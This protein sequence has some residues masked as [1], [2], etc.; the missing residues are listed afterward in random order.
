MRE[1]YGKDVAHIM[2]IVADS[3]AGGM[4]VHHRRPVVEITPIRQRDAGT[5]VIVVV[6]FGTAKIGAGRY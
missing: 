3:I 1:G 2:G 5:V 4:P 6:G